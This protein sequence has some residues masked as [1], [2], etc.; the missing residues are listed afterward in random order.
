MQFTFRMQNILEKMCTLV[1]CRKNMVL[2]DKHIKAI[3]R[4]HA[5]NDALLERL[6]WST[7]RIITLADIRYEIFRLRSDYYSSSE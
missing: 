3:D 2:S 5:I 7:Q 6:S 4:I 1:R